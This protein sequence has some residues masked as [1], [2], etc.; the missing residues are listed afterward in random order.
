[1]SFFVRTHKF[2]LERD[3]NYALLWRTLPDDRVAAIAQCWERLDS[4]S[5]LDDNA[6]LSGLHRV[7][8]R[9]TA[10]Y[11]V[12]VQE[13]EIEYSRVRPD[14]YEFTLNEKAVKLLYDDALK[15]LQI[16]ADQHLVGPPVLYGGVKPQ[17]SIHEKLIRKFDGV[18][19]QR[20]RPEVVDTWDV[21]RFRLVLPDLSTVRAASMI[22]WEVFFDDVMR[23]RNYYYRPRVNGEGDAYRAIHFE[24]LDVRGRVI[25]VQMISRLREVISLFDHSF[26]FKRR[27]PFLSL[28]H[29][30]WLRSRSLMANILD[31]DALLS[32]L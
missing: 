20:I 29:E 2:L 25:E 30:R 5:L 1:M 14:W 26:V 32:T 13:R 8:T 10:R 17:T 31:S 24:L 11:F 9:A 4:N 18:K 7:A 23:C 6:D 19:D 12:H 16:F 21:V 28:T 22:F 15:R 27:F 3:E